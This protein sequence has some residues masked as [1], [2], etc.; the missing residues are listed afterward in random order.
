MIPERSFIVLVH[1]DSYKRVMYCQNFVVGQP[2]QMSHII[3]VL[4]RGGSKSLSY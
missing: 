3:D 2:R 4:E 1:G